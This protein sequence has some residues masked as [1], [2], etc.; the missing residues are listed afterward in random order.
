MIFGA[1]VAGAPDKPTNLRI[2]DTKS[3]RGTIKA[4]WTMPTERVNG[5]YIPIEELDYVCVYVNDD[6][7]VKVDS[8][9]TKYTT[10]LPMPVGT[11]T[12]A[13]VVCDI[14]G[15]CS[16]RTPPVSVDIPE[17]YYD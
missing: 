10:P 3:A 15:L 13:L 16:D 4:T 12:V 9:G 14:W 11:H 8:P 7:C 17:D 6:P 5:D 2:T 1:A